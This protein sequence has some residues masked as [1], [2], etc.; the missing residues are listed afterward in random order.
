[1][2]IVDAG[3]VIA[4]H[5]RSFDRGQQIENP[6]HIQALVQHKRAARQHRATDRLHHAAPSA[7]ALFERTAQRGAQLGVLTRGLIALLDSHGASALEDAIAQALT[8]PAPHLGSV[9]QLLDVQRQRR[10]QPPALP[11]VLPDDPRVRDLQVR[12]HS[13]DDYQR[14][15]GDDDNDDDIN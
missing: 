14:L 9:R 10:N 2:R 6:A 5:P 7:Q 8:L 1:V 13:L 11:I 15:I 12:A 4:E 3:E